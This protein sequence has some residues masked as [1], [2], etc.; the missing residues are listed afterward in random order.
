[1]DGRGGA[2]SA[3]GELISERVMAENPNVMMLLA[4]HVTGVTINV[5]RDV[6]T[7]GNNV[8]E[9]TH[10]YQGY[11]IGTDHLGLTDIGNYDGDTPVTFGA[12]FFRLLQF[13]L[14]R[15]ELSVDTYSAHLDEFGATDYDTEGRYD[16]EAD[17]FR[18]PIQTQNRT[19]AF[20]TDA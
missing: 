13:D 16:P 2:R 4:G 18:V 9:L 11:R 20:T 1:A 12:T 15:G 3:D 8:V 17:D 14:D 7:N 10:D 6:G 19:T 5:R